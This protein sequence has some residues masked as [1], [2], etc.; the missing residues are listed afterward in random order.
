MT[1]HVT[2]IMAK[3]YLKNRNVNTVPAVIFLHNYSC[4]VFL[5][6]QQLY[7]SKNFNKNKRLFILKTI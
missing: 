2:G 6:P 1:L 5:K 7:I 3:L 4:E